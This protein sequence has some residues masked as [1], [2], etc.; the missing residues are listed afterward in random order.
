LLFTTTLLFPQNPANQPRNRLEDLSVRGKIVVPNRYQDDRIE[1][2]LEK[3]ALQVLQTTFTDSAGNFEFRNLQAGT[4]YVAVTV[5]GYE[6][7]RQGVDVFSNFGNS[8]II[9][10]FLNKAAVDLRDRLTGLDAA[11]P[12]IVDVSQM[13]ENLPK[14]A[15]QSYEKTIKEKKKGRNETTIKLLEKTVQNGPNFFKTQK[16]PGDLYQSLNE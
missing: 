10:I 15:V 11:D 14:K 6:P 5:E 13:K 4:Y 3:S 9:S 2:R 1:V 8:N 16:N 7:V 12:D